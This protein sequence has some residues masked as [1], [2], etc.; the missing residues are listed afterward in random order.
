MK[1]I[2]CT[3]TFIIS[4]HTPAYA[5]AQDIINDKNNSIVRML[6]ELKNM[7]INNTA[8]INAFNKK[9]ID[10]KALLLSDIAEIQKALDEQAEEEKLIGAQLDALQMERYNSKIISAPS[11]ELQINRR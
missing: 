10:Y 5:E 4:I 1:K 7:P 9:K 8:E 6:T 3:M 2:L 11:N